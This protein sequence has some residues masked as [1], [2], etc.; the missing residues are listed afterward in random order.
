VIIA[1]EPLTADFS[2]WVEV[3]EYSLLRVTCMKC[4][5]FVTTR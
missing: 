1:S 4:L 2:A 3:P 5:R